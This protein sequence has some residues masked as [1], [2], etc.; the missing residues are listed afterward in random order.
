MSI[1]Q[2]QLELNIFGMLIV[3]TTILSWVTSV[4]SSAAPYK[5]MCPYSLIFFHV[6][7]QTLQF[8]LRMDALDMNE[9]LC[10]HG[11]LYKKKG[12][13]ESVEGQPWAYCVELCDCIYHNDNVRQPVGCSPLPKVLTNQNPEFIIL[14]NQNSVLKY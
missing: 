8:H 10:P 6:D 1:V 14:T 3:V 12:D 5:G 11:C 4:I 7:N 2:D 9:E 13:I